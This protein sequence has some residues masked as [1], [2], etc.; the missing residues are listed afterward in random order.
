MTTLDSAE[1]M[2]RSSLTTVV[3]PSAVLCWASSRG[4]LTCV[5]VGTLRAG[6]GQEANPRLAFDSTVCEPKTRKN[7]FY[8]GSDITLDV[9]NK[10]IAKAPSELGVVT[11]FDTQE[12][13][14]DHVFARLGIDTDGAV[15]HPIVMTEILANPN[16]AR[17]GFFF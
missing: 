14:L 12:R 16:T 9:L 4:G 6:W 3:A 15:N 1:Q 2:Q 11:N 13:I 17:Q 5:G 7:E 10:C 8:V